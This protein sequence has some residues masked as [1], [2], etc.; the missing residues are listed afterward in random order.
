MS[1]F[2][3]EIDDDQPEEPRGLRKQIE[4]QAAKAREAEARA[5]AA[6]RELA[7][8]K[9]GLPLSDPKMTYFVKG[10][11][12]DLSPDAIKAAAEAAGFL[13]PAA[14]EVPAEELQQHQQVANLAASGT[15]TSTWNGPLHENPQYKQEMYAARSPEE[16]MAVMAKYGSP[17]ITDLD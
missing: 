14:P 13:T 1:E 12:G 5:A 6:E 2:D 15:P 7:F 4:E 10:Y 17:V 11:D 16:A 3:S 9:A 8:A